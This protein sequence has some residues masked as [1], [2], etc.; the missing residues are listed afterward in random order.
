MT[1]ATRDELCSHSVVTSSRY[2]ASGKQFVASGRRSFNLSLPPSLH[3][4]HFLSPLRHVPVELVNLGG[5]FDARNNN[6]DSVEI[7]SHAGGGA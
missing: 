1:E 5:S 4:W 7:H 3:K 6:G 2:C